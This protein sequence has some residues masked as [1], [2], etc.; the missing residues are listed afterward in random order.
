M[1]GKSYSRLRWIVAAIFAAFTVA[2]IALTALDISIE[3]R[4]PISP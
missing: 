2:N 4:V 1:A 3:R